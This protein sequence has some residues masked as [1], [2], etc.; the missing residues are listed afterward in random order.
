[1]KNQDDLSEVTYMNYSNSTPWPDK[2]IWHEHTYKA[3]VTIVE[4]WLQKYTNSQMVLLNAG[5]GGTEYKTGAKIIHLDIVEKYISQFDDYIVGSVE[6]IELPN[7]SLDG[8]IC[9][10]SVINYADV[11]RT[12][13]EFSRLLKPNGFLILEFERS[14]SAEFLWTSQHNKLIFQREYNY[15]S[16]KHLLW[17]YNERHICQLL[18]Q[19]GVEIQSIKRLHVL[20]SLLYRIGLTEEKAAPFSKYDSLCEFISYPLAHNAILLGRKKIFPCSYN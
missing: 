11:Q 6:K 17:M 19:Y 1:M 20:S 8:I 9:V 16:Q 5:S 10:G 18:E 2:D 3:I 14:N 12:I 7:A 4:Q 15:N 13:A